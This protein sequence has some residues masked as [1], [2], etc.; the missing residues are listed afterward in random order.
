MTSMRQIMQTLLTLKA[1]ANQAHIVAH[2]VSWAQPGLN[3]QAQ[4][5]GFGSFG[6]KFYCLTKI[7]GKVEN[8]AVSTQ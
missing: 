1:L 3:E 4:K 5:F 7:N 2:D 6:L 8:Y